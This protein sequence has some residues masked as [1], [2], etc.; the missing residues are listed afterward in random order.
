MMNPGIRQVVR[1]FFIAGPAGAVF[2]VVRS[3]ALDIGAF[4]TAVAAAMGSIL[5]G[6][7]SHLVSGR[8]DVLPALGGWSLGSVAGAMS[9]SLW[10][11]TITATLA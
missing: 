11:T 1:G 5:C 10:I 4:D 7:V 8:K 6:A 9:G 2:S 3:R